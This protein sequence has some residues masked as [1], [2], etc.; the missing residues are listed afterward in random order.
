MLAIELIANEILPVH[1]SDSI[2]APLWT[3]WSNLG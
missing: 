2:S 1:T 3:A